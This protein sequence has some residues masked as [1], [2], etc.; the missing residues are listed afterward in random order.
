MAA[1]DAEGNVAA[2]ITSITSG[3]GSLV[4][5]P[6]T[7]IILNNAMQNFD[8]RPATMNCIR[9]GKMPIFA[10]PALVAARDGHACFAGCG[11]GGYRIVTA[12]LHAFLHHLDFGMGPQAAIDAPRVHCQ[13]DQTFV[14]A[15]IA[16]AI[17]DGLAGLGHDVVVQAESPGLNAF[18]RVNA[19]AIKGGILRAGTGPAWSSAAAAL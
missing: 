6:G 14:D 5:V 4:L 3:L 9:P 13:G 19:I 8:P 16:P 10:A 17:R 12:V 2:L 11:S 18:G 1:A 7:G 15:R